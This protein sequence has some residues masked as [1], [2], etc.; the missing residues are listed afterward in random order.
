M[1]NSNISV[2]VRSEIQE[3]NTVNVVMPLKGEPV[4][5]NQGQ[6]VKTTTLNIA[7]SLPEI[8]DCSS[9]KVYGAEFSGEV[10]S[11]TTTHKYAGTPFETHIL[12]CMGD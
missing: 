4:I 12:V 7:G 11:S 9:I 6:D 5:S 2:L 10:N 3:K 1:G 8:N